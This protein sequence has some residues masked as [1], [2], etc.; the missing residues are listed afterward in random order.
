MKK[1]KILIVD[2]NKLNRQSLADIFRK[3]YQIVES[4]DGKKA[5]EYLK[6]DKGL[7]V[8]AIILDLI[9]PVMDG[10]AFLE[11]FKKHSEYKYIPIVIA[12]TEDNVENEKRC[13]EYGVWDFIPKSFH[14]EIIWFRVMNA[15]KRSKQHF[16]EYD[17]LTGIYN[18]Q[19]FYQKTRE[20]LDDSKD[21]TFAFIRLDIDRFK[22]INSF[23]GAAEGDRLL[24]CMAHNICGVLSA[25]KTYT[26]GRLNS[27]VFGICVAVEKEQDALLIAQKIRE[28][29]KKNGELRCYLETS[30]GCYI[31]RDK[32]MEVSAIYEHAVIAAQECKGQYMH[33]EALYTEQMGKEMQR[34]QQIINEMDTA[35]EEKQFVVYFQPKYELDG[36][37]PRGAEALVRW[38]KPDGTMV[39]PGEFIPVF[40]RNG[41]ITKLDYYVWEQTCIQLR[42]W[43]DEGKNPLPISVNL[44]RVSL[45]NKDIVNVICNLVDS[46]RIPRRLFQVE[47]TESAYNTNPKAV[48]DMMQRLREE[49][50]YILM[51]DFGSGYSSLNVLKDIV[52]DV[53]KMD[54]KFFA[55][56]DREGRGENIMAAV[57]RMAKWLNMPV[58]AEG[59]ERIEQVEFL[60]SIGCEYVQ[61]YYF[62]KPM[63]VEE[64]EKL[65]FDRPHAE[66]KKE[67]E[68]LVDIDSLWTPASQL[69][70]LFLN[71]KQGVAV[72][73]YGKEQIEIIRVNNAYYE[74]FGYQD[75]SQKKDIFQGIP[76]RYHK[77]I[78][79]A[80]FYTADKGRETQCEFSRKNEAGEEIFIS[81]KLYDVGIVG[82]KHI[83]YG[84][85]LNVT[86]PKQLEWELEK[87]RLLLS[88]KTKDREMEQE[89]EQSEE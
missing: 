4:E 82:N 51:D 30:A 72:Y 77:R 46:Y 76:K 83:I 45:Y 75:I 5:L 63:P 1:N 34:E 53:L 31:I 33:H 23:Y 39:S 14:R 57:I 24:R 3:A 47:L 36:Y 59:V 18:R 41:F 13:L 66:R 87:Y 11:E 50:F 56:D 43:M 60:R 35:L 27:D 88:G 38:K 79:D 78:L 54:M 17:S 64:Y 6:K 8:A 68:R 55:G 74:V 16:L 62:A 21:E 32:E 25:Y 71:A 44:S 86:E 65:Q 10:F 15:I 12:T 61:G 69:E 26:Y 9:M 73:E 81:L 52:V 40:E 28:Q 80:F 67:T 37:T 89:K 49:G 20:M 22:M 84:V 7:S 29:V 42:K 2:D 70:S 19:M 58:V 48:Q 85:F